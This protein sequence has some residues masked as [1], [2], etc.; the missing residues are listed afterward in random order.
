MHALPF[1]ASTLRPSSINGGPTTVTSLCA[2]W[3][4]SSDL[5][6]RDFFYTRASNLTSHIHFTSSW[7]WNWAAMSRTTNTREQRLSFLW[8]LPETSLVHPLTGSLIKKCGLCITM[9]GLLL[10]HNSLNFR[11]Q[12]FHR[13][14][15]KTLLEPQV[16]TS[17]CKFDWNNAGFC[18]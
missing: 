17:A 5:T 4:F 2:C 12:L 1:A 13:F 18:Q 15:N 6:S 14:L 11:A 10:Y 8:L 3:N 16:W 7:Y 9:H